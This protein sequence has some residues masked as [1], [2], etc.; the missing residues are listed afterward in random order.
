MRLPRKAVCLPV[1]AAAALRMVGV[2]AWLLAMVVAPG[3]VAVVEAFSSLRLKLRTMREPI[4]LPPTSLDVAVMVTAGLNLETLTAIGVNKTTINKRQLPHKR[5]NRRWVISTWASMPL[6]HHSNL[7][8]VLEVQSTNP[9]DLWATF[10]TQAN[11]SCNSLKA[12][13]YCLRCSRRK[14]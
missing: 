12:R 6:L 4:R 11:R 13:S 3:L 8:T 7:V 14:A 2:R 1:E 9:S 10:S 5:P